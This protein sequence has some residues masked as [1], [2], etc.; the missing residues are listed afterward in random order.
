[1]TYSRFALVIALG[2]DRLDEEERDEDTA[3]E[4]MIEGTWGGDGDKCG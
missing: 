3:G 1:M 2:D 4:E